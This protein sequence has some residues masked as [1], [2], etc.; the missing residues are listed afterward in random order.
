MPE[1]SAGV[2]SYHSWKATLRND[3]IVITE[4]IRF[5]LGKA[6]IKPESKGVIADIAAL[7]KAH[8]GISV[9]IEAHT[10]VTGT[11]ESNMQMSEGRARSV[12]QALVDQGVSA[13]RLSAVGRG[14]K[15]PVVPNT[16]A[17]NRARNR[18]IEFIVRR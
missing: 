14:Q 16:T 4:K 17:E 12:M 5:S 8:A 10:G 18:R 7:I 3:A 15:R 2:G 11:A 6:D 13:S 9:A 1:G